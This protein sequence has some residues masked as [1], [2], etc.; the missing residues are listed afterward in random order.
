ME[1]IQDFEDI[2]SVLDKHRVRHLI[3]G[4]LAFI[5][6]VKPRYTKDM[7]L[8]VDPAA[9]N[10][11]RANAALAEFGSPWLFE[12]SD[13]NQVVQVGLPPNRI[14]LL[15]DA[16][17]VRFETAWKKR[18]R[19]PYGKA[20]ANWVDLDTLIRIKSPIE[21]SRHQEDVRLLREIKKRRAKRKRTRR[22]SR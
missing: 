15:L 14:D 10:L 20:P 17:S 19:R 22:T 9:K 16:G 13:T 8:W 18:I 4:G 21:V 2:L 3:I 11:E 7:D 6:H 1:T 5:F 12:D